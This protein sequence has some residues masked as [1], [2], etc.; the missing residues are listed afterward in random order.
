MAM[1]TMA[2]AIYKKMELNKPYTSSELYNLVRDEYPA[3]GE[4]VRKVVAREMWK[5]V[6]AGYA[7]TY[8]SDE[9]FYNVRGTRVGS[10]IQDDRWMIY[11]VR[12][13]VRVR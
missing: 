8:K 6:N 13:W 5:V 7:K 9:Q 11:S 10:P 2:R 3:T 12:Y 1:E 4:D